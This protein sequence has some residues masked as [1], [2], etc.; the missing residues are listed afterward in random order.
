MAWNLKP[1]NVPPGVNLAGLA[2]H[3]GLTWDEFSGM[4]PAYRKTASPPNDQSTAYLPPS[5]TVAA[6][7]W[8]ASPQARIFAGMRE[9]TVRKGDTLAS[10]AR[11]HSVSEDALGKA[12]GF[13]ALPA[14][15][16]VI[17]IPPRDA[18]V[19]PVYEA[20]PQTATAATA[21]AG[22]YTVR[23]GDTL[24]SLAQVWGT[25]AE[26]IRLANRMGTRESQLTPGQR[27]SIPGN[28]K[29]PKARPKTQAVEKAA[30]AP[31][32]QAEKSSQQTTAYTV[33]KGDTAVKIARDHGITLAA[34]C[35]A[36]KL[37]K[38]KPSVKPGQK[39]TIP[40]GKGGADS[41][42]SYT[43]RK[44]DTVTLIA[45][46]TGVS[47]NDLC[48]AN[49]LNKK[50]PAIRPGQKLVIPGK[51]AAA[52]RAE[53]PAKSV[54]ADKASGKVSTYTVKAGDTLFSVSRA[55]GASVDDICKA[56]KLN[57]NKPSLR[58]GQKL[59]IP[60]GAAKAAAPEK[61]REEKARAPEKARPAEKAKT[62]E[63]EKGKDKGRDKNADKGK[64]GDAEPAKSGSKVTVK[65]GETLFGIARANS[66]SVQAL[67]KAN[68]LGS[69]TKVRVGQKLIIP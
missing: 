65:K 24:T 11:Q 22:T 1:M 26:S 42:G 19:E 38:K 60:G 33:K 52:E 13:V 18:S 21:S 31:V 28:A 20:L 41:S 49:K 47:Y 2:H 35:D 50:K 16:S 44:G 53:A 27:I 55:T 63:R 17:L 48:D 23:S 30:P 45:K 51:G 64:K 46:K 5:R 12:N 25:D 37:N 8:V 40:G 29:T 43:V 4:N 15:G 32:K 6:I 66:V 62:P 69:S 3:L 59:A 14:R 34:L 10:V 61:A 54:K 57:K 58:P 67:Q 56:N 36:N 9:Y 7:N 68:N 39:L